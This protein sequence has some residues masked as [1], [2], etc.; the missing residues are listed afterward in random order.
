MQRVH[1]SNPDLTN[2]FPCPDCSCVFNK[3][4][5]LNRHS[6]KMHSTKLSTIHENNDE[7]SECNFDQIMA[8]LRTIAMPDTTS[9]NCSLFPNGKVSSPVIGSAGMI[10]D[11]VLTAS[12]ADCGYVKIVETLNSAKEKSEVVVKQVEGEDGRKYYCCDICSKR[13]QRPHDLLK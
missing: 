5:S 11:D 4:N 3:L 9:D 13:F 8:K 10:G 6:A 1:P 12:D 7:D 2:K